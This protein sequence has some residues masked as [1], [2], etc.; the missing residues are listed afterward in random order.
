MNMLKDRLA[1]TDQRLKE[2]KEGRKAADKMR[3]QACKQNRA[4]RDRKMML[5]GEAV[6][7]R[8]ERG[9]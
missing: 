3:R 5:V 1:V 2:L 9:E 6:L 8:V 7:R 4:D